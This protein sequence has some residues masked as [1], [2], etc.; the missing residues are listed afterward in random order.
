MD[1]LVGGEPEAFLE[2]SKQLEFERSPGKDRT[3]ERAAQSMHT[4]LLKSS[5]DSCAEAN[6]IQ[7]PKRKRETQ[8]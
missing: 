1:V 5:K 6:G 2:L 8:D 7:K 4:T 3:V